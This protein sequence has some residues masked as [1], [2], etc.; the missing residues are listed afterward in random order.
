VILRRPTIGL[1]RQ[2]LIRIRC[3][4]KIDEDDMSEADIR[5]KAQDVFRDVFDDDTITLKDEITAR[6]IDGWD[7]VSNVRLMVSLE[8]KFGVQFDAAE[9]TELRN[10]GELL[11]A[12]RRHQK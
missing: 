8:E 4:R 5:I 9:F 7:S 11:A 10:V 12:I 3:R 1:T 2:T 6:D